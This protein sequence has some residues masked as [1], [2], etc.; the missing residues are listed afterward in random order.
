MGSPQRLEGKLQARRGPFSQNCS[1]I[2]LLFSSLSLFVSVSHR[3]TQK[4]ILYTY[5]RTG[6]S[7]VWHICFLRWEM[8]WLVARW[9][10]DFEEEV[11]CILL[12]FFFFIIIFA[13]DFLLFQPFILIDLQMLFIHSDVHTVTLRFYSW[14]YLSMN[15]W[16]N[17]QKINR[18][19]FWCQLIKKSSGFSFSMWIYSGY[20]SLLW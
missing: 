9:F 15:R 17:Q 1:N 14:K 18:Q 19:L 7:I 13:L 10:E 8:I 2:S 11:V 5:K 16:G 3:N 4:H 12:F 20:L 6:A